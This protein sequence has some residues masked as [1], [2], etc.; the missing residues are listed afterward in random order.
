VH[1][2]SH[3]TPSRRFKYLKPLLESYVQ[4]FW[5]YF[6]VPVTETQMAQL[7]KIKSI[8]GPALLKNFTN[9]AEASYQNLYPVKMWATHTESVDGQEAQL[10]LWPHF[11]KSAER[12]E[13]RHKGKQERFCANME[14]VGPMG[15]TEE[16]LSFKTIPEG[17][18]T[19]VI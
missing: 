13:H 9:D 5:I 3:E 6:P 19:R 4:L 1:V 10:L 8:R 18:D 11:W 2:S 14:K 16:F 15:W 12:A 17:L 7:S